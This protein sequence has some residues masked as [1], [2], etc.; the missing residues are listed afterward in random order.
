MRQVRA[1][2]TVLVACVIGA[3]APAARA[4]ETDCDN[5]SLEVELEDY[6]PT[7]CYTDLVTDAEARAQF[8]AIFVEGVSSYALVVSAQDFAFTYLPR[9]TM[10]S[11]IEGLLEEDDRVEW[12]DGVPHEG[13]TVQRFATIE[14]SGRETNCV[15][16]SRNT[17]A[18]NGRPRSRLYGYICMAGRGELEEESVVAFIGAIDD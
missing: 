2:V 4:G 8:E 5:I 13:Y 10:E 14:N 15:G 3:L 16:F 17:A 11:L 18:P 9:Q 7:W 6:L 12:R 1:I